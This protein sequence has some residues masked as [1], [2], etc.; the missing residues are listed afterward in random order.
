MN[1]TVMTVNRLPVPTWNWLKM[2]GTD[3]ERPEA[4]SR[5]NCDVSLPE[6]VKASDGA[7]FAFGVETD[8]D[9]SLSE[10]GIVP[11][12]YSVSG[13]VTVPLRLKFSLGD[14]SVNAVDIEAAENSRVSV[15]MDYGAAESVAGSCGVRTRLKLARNARVQL[16]QIQDLPEKACFFNDV[17]VQCAEG[18]E[19]SLVQ[20][21][22]GCGKTFMGTSCSLEGLSSAFNSDIGYV[23][24]GRE[25]LD[26]NSVAVHRG[27]QTSSRINVL[28]VLRDEGSKIFRG[29]IDFRRGALQAVGNEKED[30]LL[31]DDRV[32]NQTIPVILC[33]EED[34]EGNH[35]A[36]IGRL[37]DG[38]L[39]YMESRGLSRAQVYEMMARARMAAACGKIADAGLR[40]EIAHRF[41]EGGTDK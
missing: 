26:I 30:V 15:L 22:Q 10:S 32:V 25:K 6:G 23:V 9:D 4:V 39:F 7:E 40:D 14:S 38:L 2:N 8:L 37:D 29:T 34:V 33:E 36:T 3:V 13:T 5:G 12:T 41:D 35:G 11:Q 21:V 24:K 17:A 19:I 18:A 28:G 20:L 31:M 27:R 1:K 16:V